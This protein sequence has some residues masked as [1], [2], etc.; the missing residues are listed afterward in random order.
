MQYETI[1]VG[2]YQVKKT[3][4]HSTYSV[5]CLGKQVETGQQVRLRIWPTAHVPSKEE[6]K[7]FQAEVAAIQQVQHPYLLPIVEVGTNEQGVFLASVFIE[8]DSLHARQNQ[9]FLKPLPLDEALEIIKAVGQALHALHE[10]GITHGNLAPLAVY[11]AESGQVYLG[12][13]HL[14]GI[15]KHIQGHQASL[16]EN[17][18]RCW[19]MAPEQFSGQLTSQTDQY[20]LGCLGYALLTGRV[21]FAGSSR[22]ALLQKHQNDQPKSLSGFNSAVSAQI[23]TAILKA[24]AKQPAERHS[25]VAAFLE[26]MGL[27]TSSPLIVEE[28]AG[29]VAMQS[30]AEQETRVPSQVA[31]EQGIISLLAEQETLKQPALG[32]AMGMGMDTPNNVQ[33][34][35]RVSSARTDPREGVEPL[36]IKPRAKQSPRKSPGKRV[37]LIVAS[38]L[39]LLLLVLGGGGL[40]LFSREHPPRQQVVGSTTTPSVQLTADAT[41][42][43]GGQAT[44]TSTVTSIT[45]TQ[46]PTVQ[47][48]ATSTP[49]VRPTAESTPTATST[50]TSLAVKPLLKCVQQNNNNMYIAH[51]GYVNS[52]KST[53]TIP[54]GPNNSLSSS[55]NNQQPTSFNPGTHDDVV[56]VSFFGQNS[57]SWTLNGTTVTAYS[58]SH[59]C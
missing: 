9:L 56:Q 20:A 6:Q 42:T 5:L 44:Q 21:P 26:A 55:P 34:A 30:V 16:D 29:P 18:P 17:I 54:V 49:G 47:A 10:H 13:I 23:E 58:N 28:A 27:P 12:E 48:R 35:Q 37:L 53:V 50:P 38:L 33:S 51:F 36:G 59:K 57:V 24:L 3:L 40:Q 2:A 15:Q 8:A 41:N 7:R 22:A 25:S 43:V 19:Y 4:D 11:V 31:P 1:L 52:G 45:L 39:L 32:L 46:T 14:P